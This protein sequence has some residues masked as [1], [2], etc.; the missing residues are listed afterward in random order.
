MVNDRNSLM[1]VMRE[2]AREIP[3]VADCDLCVIGGSCTGVFA[4]LSA[5]RLGAKVA[6]VEN[7]GFFGGTATA[8]L[9]PHWKQIPYD[10]TG[11]QQIIAGLTMEVIERLKK[12]RSCFEMEMLEERTAAGDS[13]KKYVEGDSPRSHTYVLNSEELKVELDELVTEAGVRPFLHTRFV[14]PILRDGKLDAIAVED[15]SGRR[16]IRA[17]Y[18]VDATGDGD[19]IARMGLPCYKRGHL[20]APSTCAVIRGLDEIQKSHPGFSLEQA[21]FDPKHPNVI[22][23]GWFR[24][25]KIPDSR[26]D[27]WLGGTTVMGGVDCSDA[28]Q[29]T[30]AEI[31]GRRQVRAYCDILRKN[32]TAGDDLG[33]LVYLA[34]V[35]G[36]RE[37]RHARCLYALTE[38]ELLN[39]RRFHDAIA[40][41]IKGVDIHHGVKPGITLRDLDGTERYHVPGEPTKLSRWRDKSSEAAA[42]WQIPYRSL[43]PQGATNV[44]VAGRGIDA[45][46]GAFAAIRDMPFCNQEGEA[47]GT[48]SYLALSGNISVAEIDT[49]KLRETMR[50]QG[51]VII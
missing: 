45:D 24:T 51:S 28:D 38:T 8:S 43:V 22:G 31:E 20:Q 46:V 26:D 47:V 7:N 3:I 49:G 48:A 40:N 36:I 37:T 18:F 25:A 16:G 21:A 14:S 30:K 6:I 23:K 44:L 32:I 42:F 39:G 29:L 50:K 41:G 19:L 2:E 13:H 34:S 27:W 4:A 35:I 33:P 12:R 5:A 10:T 1:S 15:K 11:H 17:S 9:W